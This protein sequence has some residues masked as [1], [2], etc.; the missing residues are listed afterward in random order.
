MQSPSSDRPCP[1]TVGYFVML[2]YMSY[3]IELFLLAIL[4]AMAG[5]AAFHRQAAAQ[6]PLPR[7]WRIGKGR[8]GGY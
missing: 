6:S 4:G 7:A 3:E 8:F 2:A 5:Y 1:L